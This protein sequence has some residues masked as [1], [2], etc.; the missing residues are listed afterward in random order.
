MDRVAIVHENFLRRV[1]A[2][3]FPVSTSDK[4][5]LDRAALEQQRRRGT[6]EKRPHGRDWPHNRTALEEGLKILILQVL[7][8]CLYYYE[9]V[10]QPELNCKWIFGVLG[11][12]NQGDPGFLAPHGNSQKY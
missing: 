5:A 8:I 3:D 4:K 1:A 7:T 9:I 2:G 10:D 12:S 6:F 11:P